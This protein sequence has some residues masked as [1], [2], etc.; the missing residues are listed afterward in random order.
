MP[1]GWN[2]GPYNTCET[3][4][5]RY[6]CDSFCTEEAGDGNKLTAKTIVGYWNFTGESSD[7]N[8][9]VYGN[10]EFFQG[11]RF[12]LRATNK[13][14]DGDVDRE[15]GKGTWE[16]VGNQLTFGGEGGMRHKGKV[17]GDP[18]A[19]TMHDTAGWTLRFKKTSRTG[20]GL[21]YPD[22]PVKDD[23]IDAIG[24]LGQ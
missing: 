4:L 9:K 1:N 24:T 11:G 22:S 17:Q 19:F 14:Q 8:T 15:E 20:G 23:P 5:G 21:T 2:P 16:L 6:N 13:Q 3:L 7:T 12:H 18:S 10:I